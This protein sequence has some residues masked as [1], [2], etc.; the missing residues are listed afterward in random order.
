MNQLFFAKITSIDYINKR[1]NQFSIRL[2]IGVF[3]GLFLAIGTKLGHFSISQFSYWCLFIAFI[4]STLLY[5]RLNSQ[6]NPSFLSQMSMAAIDISLMSW[7]IYLTADGIPY[8]GMFYLLLSISYSLHND[9]RFSIIS[10]LIILLEYNLLLYLTQLWLII[11]FILISQMLILLF[12]PLYCQILWMQLHRA[13]QDAEQ[14]TELKSQFLAFMTHEIRNPLNAILGSVHLLEKTELNAPQKKYLHGLSYSSQFLRGLIDDILDFS[15]IEA[16]KLKLNPVEFNLLQCIEQIVMSQQAQIAQTNLQISFNPGKN[17]PCYV[18]ADQ[19]RLQQ[20]LLNLVTNAIKNIASKK[21]QININLSLQSPVNSRGKCWIKFEV[22]DNGVG[23][24][25][26]AQKILFENYTQ[27]VASSNIDSRSQESAQ[28][29]HGKN[30]SHLGGTGLGMAIIKELVEIMGGKIELKSEKGI[31]SQF[32]FSL[33][34]QTVTRVKSAFP[35]LPNRPALH[36]SLHVLVAEDEEINAMVSE[37]F[38][39]DL[40]HSVEMVR[41][42]Q[43]ALKKLMGKQY[44]M[45]FMDMHMPYANGI[46]VAQ[47]FRQSNSITPIIGVTASATKEQREAC[48]AAGMSDFLS[49]PITPE[50]L[51]AIIEKHF[52]P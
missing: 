3:S 37:Q 9:I 1:I 28:P 26:E 44:D 19:Q 42:G 36:Q 8:F 52:T 11:P 10:S 46:Q 32:Y 40:G 23:I 20:I 43:Q 45:V 41:D 13:K 22:C 30:S 21:G 29:I 50:K 5:S 4:F 17:I 25:K 16:Q 51:S 18:R 15:K 35:H 31:G 12:L 34:L 38:L 39:K 49:K 6:N 7:A 27:I 33:P 2:V 48:L 47:K 14:L 24:D